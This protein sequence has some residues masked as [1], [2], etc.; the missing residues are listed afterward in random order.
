MTAEE[1][2][3]LFDI[4][5]LA[6]SGLHG[7]DLARLMTLVRQWGVASYRAGMRRAAEVIRAR[8]DEARS[9]EGVDPWVWVTAMLSAVQSV[10]DS[11]RR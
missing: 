10:A 6:T 3:L 4:R 11:E 9:T 2:S 7:R 8:A 5:H 1:E